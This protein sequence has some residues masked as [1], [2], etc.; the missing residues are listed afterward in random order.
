[1]KSLR[2]DQIK[3]GQRI[4]LSSGLKATVLESHPYHG[5]TDQWLLHLDPII[6]KGLEP[7]HF[8]TKPSDL[9]ELETTLEVVR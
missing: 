9:I 5:V 1:M 2:A 8:S 7:F 4:R 3:P 6:P